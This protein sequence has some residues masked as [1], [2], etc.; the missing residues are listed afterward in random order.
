MPRHKYH[1]SDRRTCLCGASFVGPTLA[2]AR[3][4][5][6]FPLLCRKSKK[7]RREDA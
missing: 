2:E 6:N 5:H 7:T 3:H 1:W 4:R